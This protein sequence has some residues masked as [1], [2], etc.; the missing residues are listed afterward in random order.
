M[1]IYFNNIIQSAIL[2]QIPTKARDVTISKSNFQFDFEY[3]YSTI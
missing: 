2:A 3:Q 1:Y